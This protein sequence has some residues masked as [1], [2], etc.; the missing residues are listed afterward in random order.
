M[1]HVIHPEHSRVMRFHPR[2]AARLRLFCFPYAGGSAALFQ[3]WAQPGVLPQEVEVCAVELPGRGERRQERLWTQ[4]SDLVT[5]LTEMLLPSLQDGRSFALFGHSL[6]AL[7]SFEVARH[8]QECCGLVPVE[9]FVSGCSAPQLGDTCPEI[10]D[11]PA[12]VTYLRQL[13]AMPNVQMLARRWPLFQADFALRASYRYTAGGPPLACPITVFGGIQD[14]SVSLDA[15]SAWREQT[16]E[17]CTVHLLPGNHFFLHHAQ[18][19]LLRH[20]Q[21]ALLRVLREIPSERRSY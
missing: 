7:V 5:V 2:S 21:S 11:V 12:L 18:G 19:Q 10:A 8:L 20:L 3:R 15:L 6:G 4:F 17:T 14:D 16:L 1:Q 9:L 13:G